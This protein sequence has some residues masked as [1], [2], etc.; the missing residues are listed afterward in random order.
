MNHVTLRSMSA[1]LMSA[2]LLVLPSCSSS[3]QPKAEQ[4]KTAAFEP[5]VPGGVAVETT[6]FS[7]RIVS[8]FDTARQIVLDLPD[9]SRK[10]VT[11]GPEIINFDQLHKND[12]VKITVTE[13]LAI[14]MGAETD[15]PDTG[16]DTV[17]ALSPK[18]GTPGAIM[19]TTKQVTATVTSIDLANHTAMLTFP[20]GQTHKVVVRPDVDL[21]KRK[22]GEK[23]VIRKTDAFAIRVDKTQG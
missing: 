21:T 15:P 5:G 9:G 2:V 6:T 13:E 20:D 17:I 8:V 11:C 22:V 1:V 4:A 14:A 10:T 7:A 12:M 16:R 3:P 19:A 23:V 18:G